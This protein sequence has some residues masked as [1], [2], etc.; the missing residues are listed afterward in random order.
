MRKYIL[1]KNSEECCH[2]RPHQRPGWPLLWQMCIVGDLG[3]GGARQWDI[4]ICRPPHNRITPTSPPLPA[5]ACRPTY[6]Y[7]GQKEETGRGRATPWQTDAWIGAWQYWQYCFNAGNIWLLAYFD[8]GNFPSRLFFSSFLLYLNVG[9][10]PFGAKKWSH[11]LII[12]LAFEFVQL[13][14]WLLNLYIHVH[15]RWAL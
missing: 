2:K 6:S 14:I 3:R 1:R 9:N 8:I 5:P 4:Q 12:Y 10:I 7:L 15:L 11:R 13:H